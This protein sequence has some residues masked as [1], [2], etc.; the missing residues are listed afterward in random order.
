MFDLTDRAASGHPLVVALDAVESAISSAGDAPM[1]GLRSDELARLVVAH[2]ALTARL[3]GLGLGLV[4]EADRR[5][6][7]SAVGAPSTADWLRDRLRLDHG[8]AKGRVELAAVLDVDAGLFE[9]ARTVHQAAGGGAAVGDHRVGYPDP[10]G[11]RATGPEAGAVDAVAR[12]GLGV[13]VAALR[14]LSRAARRLLPCTAWA[15]REGRVCVEHAQVIRRALKRLP[16]GIDAMVWAECEAFLAIHATRHDPRSLARLGSHLATAVTGAHDLAGQD[17]RVTAASRAGE[18]VD[19]ARGDG[20]LDGDRGEERAEATTMFGFADNG[21]GTVRAYGCFSAE[22]AD[23]IT[24][25]LAALAAPAP[26]ADGTADPRGH[27]TRMGDALVELCR[28]AMDAGDLLPGARGARPHLTITASLGTLRKQPGCPK[29]VSMWGTPITPE[30]LRRLACDA[31]VSRVLTDPAGVP[32]DVGRQHRTVTPGQWVALVARD[33]GCAF[34]GCAR[35]AAW[36]QAHHITHWADGGTTDLDNLVLLCGHHH[37][38]VHHRGWT[39]RMGTNGHP[40][41]IPPPWIDPARQPRRNI[42]HRVLD[43]VG[44]D[45]LRL[46]AVAGSRRAGP[47]KDPPEQ[48]RAA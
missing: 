33:Q 44:T 4:R 40:T 31:G 21:D 26:A 34:P 39:V 43:A 19:A 6:A 2:E 28:R 11:D 3:A 29:A 36:T 14:E 47:P 30:A 18:V 10:A 35:P 12:T 1:W 23:L 37:R 7:G 24:T 41:F 27:A 13:P 16:A 5:G 48:V 22:A 25:A 8:V 42:Y 38:S 46:D 17:E 20:G 45:P 9:A 32:L 15:L